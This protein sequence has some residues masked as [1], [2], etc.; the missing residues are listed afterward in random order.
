MKAPK[1]ILLYSGT[2]CACT[3]FGA[4]SLTPIHTIAGYCS[5]VHIIYQVNN[6]KDNE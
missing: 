6:A 3:T 5:S 4:S 1:L 2:S